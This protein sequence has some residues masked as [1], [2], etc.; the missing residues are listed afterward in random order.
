MYCTDGIKGTLNLL[1]LN[2][3][4]G[5][6]SSW[7]NAAS[8]TTTLNTNLF[9]VIHG[10]TA[11]LDTVKVSATEEH[12]SAVVVTGSKQGITNP[13]RNVGMSYYFHY[14]I[15]LPVRLMLP[16]CRNLL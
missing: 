1:A 14:I 15:E 3:G 9:G 6:P 4:T 8:F 11:L 12:P 2:A 5:V 16:L 7:S 10:I 13:P